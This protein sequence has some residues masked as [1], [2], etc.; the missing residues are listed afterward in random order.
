MMQPVQQRLTDG[1]LLGAR[2]AL[3]LAPTSPLNSYREGSVALLGS[4][5][6]VERIQAAARGYFSQRGRESM[7]GEGLE[8]AR[9]DIA[10]ILN[11]AGLG[12]D[13]VKFTD[14]TV[15]SPDGTWLL[16]S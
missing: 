15:I 13:A 11:N 9:K 10:R 8:R 12:V 14:L 7:R 5:H 4:E 2:I 3:D 16:N 1:Y 6:E